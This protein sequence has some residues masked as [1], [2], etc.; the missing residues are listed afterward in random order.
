MDTETS[1]PRLKKKFNRMFHTVPPFS[2]LNYRSYESG[3]PMA[4][5]HRPRAAI[6][7]VVCNNTFA[8]DGTDRVGHPA[9][10]AV[11]SAVLLA[12]SL[13]AV[14]SALPRIALT[15]GL[16][17]WAERRLQQAGFQLID[18]PTARVPTLRASYSLSSGNLLRWP[19][20][21]QSAHVQPRHD[22][23]CTT[24]KLLAWSLTWYDAVLVADV[25]NVFAASPDSW[26]HA[27]AAAHEPP[28]PSDA[29]A[30]TDGDSDGTLAAASSPWKRLETPRRVHYFVA[31]R[32]Q[33]RRNYV[34]L[35]TH[36]MLI[37]PNLQASARAQPPPCALSDARRCGV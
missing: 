34:G 35:N 37:T 19:R 31:E 25:D 3:E 30:S 24:M 14:G 22:G 10:T 32:E 5:Q 1:E 29:P 17:P 26:V 13:S 12:C 2:Q 28:P 11:H 7:V 21:N 8:R 27:V 15:H 16:E 18:V 33:G 36:L 9:S 4:P 20:P 6:A 23:R